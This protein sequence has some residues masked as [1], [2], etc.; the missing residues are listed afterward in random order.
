MNVVT[1][2]MSAPASLNRCRRRRDLLLQVQQENFKD[3][4]ALVK[5]PVGW[6]KFFV[7]R[8][9]LYSTLMLSIISVVKVFQMD[10]NEPFQEFFFIISKFNIDE[11]NFWN[12][13]IAFNAN[14]TTC[15]LCTLLV[16]IPPV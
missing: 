7:G 9:V 14:F 15:I 8:I 16:W 10:S 13:L 2:K 3:C 4:R 12:I 5:V 11:A 6:S 1:G